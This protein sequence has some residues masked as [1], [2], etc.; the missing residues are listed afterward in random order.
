MVQP[1]KC[2]EINNVKQFPT[3]YRSRIYC[4]KFLTLSSQISRYKSKCIRIVN[5]LTHTSNTKCLKI[6]IVEIIVRIKGT[7]FG[8]HPFS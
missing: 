2:D 1:T 6:I 8:R 4:R 5:I 3:I 7:G